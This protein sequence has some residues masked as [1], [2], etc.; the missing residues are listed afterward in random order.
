MNNRR[1]HAATWVYKVEEWVYAMP[2][3]TCQGELILHDPL[4]CS[5][6]AW[7]YARLVSRL[8][9]LFSYTFNNMPQ[10]LSRQRTIPI[11]WPRH[12]S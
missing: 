6:G 8:S 5:S 7:C 2:A 1:L 4:R 12:L 11:I 9:T 3:A 10:F